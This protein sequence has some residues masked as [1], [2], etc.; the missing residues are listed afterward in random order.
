LNAAVG[1][2]H[3]AQPVEGVVGLVGGYEGGRDFKWIALDTL[4]RGGK[5]LFSSKDG[6][7]SKQ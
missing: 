5:G 4:H 3:N 2:R 1:R 7:I 6:G